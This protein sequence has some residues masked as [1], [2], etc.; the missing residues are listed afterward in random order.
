MTVVILDPTF[1]QSDHGTLL[2]TVLE[3]KG[4]KVISKSQTTTSTA[5]YT[6]TWQMECRAEWDDNEKQ[7]IPFANGESRSKDESSVLVFLTAEGFVDIIHRNQVEAWIDTIQ[8]TAKNKQ[9][10]LMIEGLDT[11]Y[12]KKTALL[13]R[14]FA[15]TVL[16][17]MGDRD[18]SNASDE[19]N[20]RPKKRSKSKYTT[21]D[22]IENGP[23]HD[24]IADALAYLQVIK[25]V[26]LLQTSNEEDSVDWLV[27][28]TTDLAK[29]TYK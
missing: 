19:P 21:V 6:L 22:L 12:K 24:Q 2:R 11:F 16:G 29:A 15:S 5:T 3:E 17:N 4:A 26:M 27:C 14:Q 1:D 23:S 9:L 13:R 20:R 25:D 7:F 28:L 8:H 10:F 18:S